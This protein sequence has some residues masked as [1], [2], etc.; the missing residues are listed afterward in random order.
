VRI[1]KESELILR[2]R[3]MKKLTSFLLGLLLISSCLA[4]SVRADEDGDDSPLMVPIRGKIQE[5]RQ[6]KMESMDAKRMEIKERVES[7][8]QEM[9]QRKEVFKERLMGIK[10]ERKKEIAERVD[11]RMTTLNKRVTTLLGQALDRLTA[12]TEKLASQTD[13]TKANEAITVAQ[14]AVNEQAVKEYVIEFTDDDGLKVGATTAKETLKADLKVV[15]D[16]VGV[17]RQA[18]KDALS[19]AQLVE[20]N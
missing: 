3:Y 11:Y 8:V 9:S 16:L 15:R 20:N 1:D 2:F 4:P 14:V 19:A 6:E 7:K 5:K 17:A 13:V 10:D 12:I 18:V